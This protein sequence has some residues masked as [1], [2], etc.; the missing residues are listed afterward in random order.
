MKR[1]TL[2]NKANKSSK[3]KIKGSITFKKS[4]N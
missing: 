2:E 3:K 4:V 1:S